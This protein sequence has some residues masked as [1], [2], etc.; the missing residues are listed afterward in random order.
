MKSLYS[1]LL[2]LSDTLNRYTSNLNMKDNDV[3]S[4]H[5]RYKLNKLTNTKYK[6]VIIPK[7]YLNLYLTRRQNG[8]IYFSCNPNPIF[9]GKS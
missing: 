8:Y 7:N 5:I 2:Y 3:N 1:Y 9:M 4:Q 6:N